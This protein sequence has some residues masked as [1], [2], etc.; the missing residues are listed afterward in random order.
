MLEEAEKRLKKV[1]E[2]MKLE[3]Q[4]AEEEDIEN[5]RHSD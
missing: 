1:E 2:L 5:S 4:Q 3:E